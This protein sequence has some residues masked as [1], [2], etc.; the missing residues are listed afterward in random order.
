MVGLLFDA[1]LLDIML[2]CPQDIN[3]KYLVLTVFD[4]KEIEKNY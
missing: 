2:L 1:I 3:E 4:R